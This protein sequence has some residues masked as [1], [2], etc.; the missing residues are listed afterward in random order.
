MSAIFCGH[1]GA[2]GHAK[3]PPI[4]GTS[5]SNPDCRRRILTA[6]GR[7]TDYGFYRQDRGGPLCWTVAQWSFLLPALQH[8]VRFHVD[9]ERGELTV[10]RN[11]TLEK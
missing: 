10:A 11:P 5:G 8:S 6:R 3:Y 4:T 2:P 1:D 9:P 7:R